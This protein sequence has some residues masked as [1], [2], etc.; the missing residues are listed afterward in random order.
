MPHDTSA[1]APSFMQIKSDHNL[2]NIF[3]SV[4]NNST[5]MKDKCRGLLV[6]REIEK[7]ALFNY[8]T[9]NHNVH[10]KEEAVRLN[11]QLTNGYRRLYPN[12]QEL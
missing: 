7:P 8:G 10:S 12:T 4:I 11:E 6:E 5:L 2:P 9:Y 1:I 3:K